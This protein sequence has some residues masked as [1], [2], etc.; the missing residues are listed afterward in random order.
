VFAGTVL[1]GGAV[2][3]ICQW[4]DGESPGALCE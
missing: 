1:Y 3:G 2:T 4:G